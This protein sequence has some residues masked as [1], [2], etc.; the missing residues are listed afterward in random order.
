MDLISNAS[1]RGCDEFTFKTV[2]Y[3]FCECFVHNKLE[4]GENYLSISKSIHI[5]IDSIIVLL[6]K[7]AQKFKTLIFEKKIVDL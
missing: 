1:E 4:K 2:I 3:F 6:L 7:L 5:P